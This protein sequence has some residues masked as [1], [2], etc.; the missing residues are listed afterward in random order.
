MLDNSDRVVHRDEI[1]GNITINLSED[2]NNNDCDVEV[3]GEWKLSESVMLNVIGCILKEW[4]LYLMTG[5]WNKSD[6]NCII[7][8]EY[9]YI[10]VKINITDCVPKR[11]GEDEQY[12]IVSCLNKGKYATTALS[13]GDGQYL[14]VVNAILE[15]EGTYQY[16]IISSTG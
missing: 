1:I 9:M 4:R 10:F 6:L 14:W 16:Q 2:S 12:F 5:T 3:G 8:I 11:T 7:I 15:T 13:S